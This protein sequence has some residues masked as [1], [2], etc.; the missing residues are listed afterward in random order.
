MVA[1]GVITETQRAVA[2]AEYRV[3][4]QDQALAQTMH[5][6]AVEGLRPHE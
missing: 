3:W 2:E 4:I 5:M 1:D 6:V